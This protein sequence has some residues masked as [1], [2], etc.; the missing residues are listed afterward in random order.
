[1]ARSS[2]YDLGITNRVHVRE[3]VADVGFGEAADDVNDGVHLPNL[4]EKLVAEPFAPAGSLDQ[5][6]DVDEPNRARGGFFRP[7]HLFQRLQSRVRHRHHA[8]VARDGREGI[9]GDLGAACRK[10]IVE[11]RFAHVW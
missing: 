5:P 8:N 7:Q 10:R 1:M 4:A 3:N 2:T 6:G 9:V 11:R